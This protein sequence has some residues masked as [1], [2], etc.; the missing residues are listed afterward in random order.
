MDSKRAYGAL[1]QADPVLA[2]LIAQY[3]TPDPFEFHDGGRTAGSNF[4]AMVL[5]ILGQQISTRVAFI[6][7]D[8]LA[9]VLGGTPTA[10]S[11]AGLGPERVKA[12]GTSRAKAVYL[13][14]L[15][16]R[17]RTGSLD[18]ERMDH[19]TDEEAVEALVAV[20]GVGQWSAEMFLIHQLRRA[21][22]LPAGD[23]GIRKA[24][25][26]AY[27]LDGVPGVDEV[28]ERGTRWA[29]YRTFASALLWSYLSVSTAALSKA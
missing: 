26:A 12:L 5:H 21:D 29:P 8:R 22:I 19:L 2:E 15:A 4:A 3:G 28:R 14:D 24:V 13:A 27:R 23:V 6:L 25:A 20:K 18:I 16:D 17:V 9:D 11:V 7:Y 10:S 1:A